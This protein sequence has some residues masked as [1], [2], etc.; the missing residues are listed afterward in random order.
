MRKATVE[1]TKRRT[2]LIVSSRTKNA[3][4]LV[5]IILLVLFWI[6]IATQQF[7]LI[8]PGIFFLLLPFIDGKIITEEEL[9]DYGG[10]TNHV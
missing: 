1:E 3:I 4:G 8:L 6:G 10:K 7:F 5:Y 9:A 2:I